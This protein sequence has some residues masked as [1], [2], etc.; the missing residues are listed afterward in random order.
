MGQLPVLIV[1][2]CALTVWTGVQTRTE[3]GVDKPGK[4]VYLYNFMLR[5]LGPIDLLGEEMCSKR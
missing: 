4:R 1:V 2:Y 3:K 5:S